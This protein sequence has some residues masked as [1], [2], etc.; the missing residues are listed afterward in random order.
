MRLRVAATALP[1][2]LGLIVPGG[3]AAKTVNYR[4]DSVKESFFGVASQ[5]RCTS[6]QT[7]AEYR[8]EVFERVGQPAGKLV[9]KGHKKPRGGTLEV[10]GY[11]GAFTQTGAWSNVN[12]G[13]SGTL[14]SGTC[15]SSYVLP[16]SMRIDF[17]QTGNQALKMRFSPFDG[18][19][20][21]GPGLTCGPASYGTGLRGESSCFG[22]IKLKRIR[23]KHVSV[24]PSICEAHLTSPEGAA[25][26][27]AVEVK[28]RLTRRG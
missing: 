8:A 21:L 10:S 6:T 2:I 27:K 26:T 5:P 13:S 12:C 24:A 14:D 17:V 1:L 11:S 15:D 9:I 25:I 4:V 3:V 23:K 28:V 19:G 7:Y 22:R 20:E 18:S 16:L